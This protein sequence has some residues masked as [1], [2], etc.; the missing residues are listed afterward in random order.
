MALWRFIEAV[1]PRF[2]KGAIVDLD[3]RALRSL[4]ETTGR[5]LSSFS[6]PLEYAKHHSERPQVAALDAELAAKKEQDAEA[7]IS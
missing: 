3:R 6:I 4:A 1:P 5:R 2:N 7:A